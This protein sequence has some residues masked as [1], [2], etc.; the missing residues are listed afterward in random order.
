MTT[1]QQIKD[2]IN[3]IL[4]VEGI[5]KHLY[6]FG[7]AMPYILEGE[8]SEREHSDIDVLVDASYM[9]ELRKLLKAHQLYRPKRDSLNLGFSG[10]YGLKVFI[11]DV[12]VEFEPVTIEE[13]VL[14]RKS[15]S[16]NL[17]IVGVESIPFVEL[18]DLIIPVQIDGVDTFS[19]T[20][21]FIKASKEL[22]VEKYGVPSIREKD[23]KDI[24]FI[25]QSGIDPKKYERVKKEFSSST[26]KMKSY[27]EAKK[28][29]NK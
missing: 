1:L 29:S 3:K 14:I 23:L 12:Y 19:V 9:E 10:D 27:E 2:V 11:D 5:G 15:F 25:N 26:I 21:E 7:G 28:E 18:T 22:A 24:D 20:L 16:P 13:N 6:F 4:S 17:E 8:E